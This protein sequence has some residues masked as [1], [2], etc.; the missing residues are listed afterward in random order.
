M[1]AVEDRT[2][3]VA[4][5]KD[6]KNKNAFIFNSSI[7][8]PTPTNKYKELLE[9]FEVSISDINELVSINGEYVCGQFSYLVYEELPYSNYNRKD[10]KL[11]NV[12]K[13]KYI[14]QYNDSEF[15]L[16]NLCLNDNSKVSLEKR[17]NVNVNQ[18][19]KDLHY[20]KLK[21]FYDH[22]EDLMDYDL[23][24]S[25]VFDEKQMIGKDVSFCEISKR[26]F[27]GD[28]NAGI[29]ILLRKKQD[30]LQRKL[31][32]CDQIKNLVFNFDVLLSAY[33]LQIGISEE[34]DFDTI[35]LAIHLSRSYPNSFSVLALLVDGFKDRII[36][37][38]EKKEGKIYVGDKQWSEV[39]NTKYGWLRNQEKELLMEAYI[40]KKEIKDY[41]M[42]RIYLY[43]LYEKLKTQSNPF[44]F[45][46]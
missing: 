5:A 3:I 25:Y 39:F 31:S 40:Q 42:C 30:D 26:Y 38:F 32:D 28:E 15:P 35:L 9:F 8:L 22:L 2:T 16:Y 45:A 18:I 11:I 19:Y 13:K 34:S 46:P 44:Y 14:D 21:Y 29:E 27:A 4:L 17:H 41:Q 20:K 36:E 6:N 37:Y 43:A 10:Q 23:V 7:G 24:K 33:K 1:E 12:E